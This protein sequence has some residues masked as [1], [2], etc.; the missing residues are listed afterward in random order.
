MQ[1]NNVTMPA[2]VNASNGTPQNELTGDAF[3][4]LLVAQLQNQDPLQPTDPTQFVGQLVQFNQLEQ[5]I[6]I[7]QIL[8]N[9]AGVQATPGTSGTQA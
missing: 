6:E 2:T 7:R 1:V 5:T 8:Q 9:I 4:T 3:L